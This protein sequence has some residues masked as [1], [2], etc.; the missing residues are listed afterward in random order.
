MA[1]L[2]V[3]L[4]PLTVVAAGKLLLRIAAEP[5]GLAPS[6]IGLAGYFA[7]WRVFRRTRLFGSFFST[8]EHELTHA[9]FAW[10]TLH[11]VVGLRATWSQGGHLR[12]LGKGNWLITISPYFF[13]TLSFTV[14]AAASCA[15]PAWHWW[16]DV[17]LGAS[18]VYHVTSTLRET[19]VGQSDLQKTGFLFAVMFLP[20]ANL[21]CFAVVVAFCHGSFPAVGG[22]FADM[23]PR[24]LTGAP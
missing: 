15:P 23:V 5:A 9:L 18:L 8:L 11:R 6:A 17:A 7:A 19:H 4:L 24:F 22:L 16:F 20:T 14:L 2:A 21:I 1:I 12:Y 10:A 3:L 13:P